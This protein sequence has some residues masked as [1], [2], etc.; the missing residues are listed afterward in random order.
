MLD[1][2]RFV[3]NTFVEAAATP[4]TGTVGQRRRDAKAAG[5]ARDAFARGMSLQAQHE[6]AAAASCFRQALRGRADL[7]PCAHYQLGR[8]LEQGRGMR[9]DTVGAMQHFVRAA[10]RGH[11]RAMYRLGLA[12]ATGR[13][14]CRD[15]IMAMN[16]LRLAAA[17][18]LSGA[19]YQLGMLYQAGGQIARAPAAAMHWLRA[20]ADGGAAAA[21]YELGRLHELGD[22]CRRDPEQAVD[23][24]RQAA[25]QGWWPAQF[26]LA[27]LHE[28]ALRQWPEG[29]AAL[30]SWRR[31]ALD[32]GEARTPLAWPAAL[33]RS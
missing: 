8:L 32:Y 1:L 22:G 29:R 13:G 30:Q 24:F 15:D 28:Q 19:Q 26:A 2:N 17:H 18:G 7:L 14:A 20:A 9:R 23:W 5:D 31:K 27:R 4:G 6:Y 25:E 21:Q 3:L 33:A 10:R 11:A 16:W 12:H